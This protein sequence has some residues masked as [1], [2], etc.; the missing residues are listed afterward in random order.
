MISDD[1]RI[2]FIQ[3]ISSAGQEAW[4]EDSA[5][6]DGVKG[7]PPEWVPNHIGLEFLTIRMLLLQTYSHDEL[8]DYVA[9]ARWL[10]DGG[11]IFEVD[12][13]GKKP[14]PGGWNIGVFLVIAQLVESGKVNATFWVPASSLDDATFWV[15]ASS[16]DDATRAFLDPSAPT[17]DFDPRHT[18]IRV[19]LSDLT[20]DED[21]IP[22]EGGDYIGY[23]PIR[24]P[25][26]ILRDICKLAQ[27][28]EAVRLGQEKGLAL[29]TDEYH[30]AITIKGE[31][32]DRGGRGPGPI[33]KWIAR[34]LKKCPTMKNADLW[35][36]FKEKP[37]RGWSVMENRQGKYLE[38]PTVNDKVSYGR[39][40]NVAKEER[41]K[42]KA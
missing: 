32:F 18:M 12:D 22:D 13:L 33:R 37:Q 15:P 42:L 1:P 20:D 3:T 11:G 28:Q 27:I 4:G 25:F 9:E 36:A 39:F 7:E 38:G 24:T 6:F 30:A 41:N 2:R 35:A 31:K 14:M 17:S 8:L 19:A 29:L 26:A 10:L 40:S 34:Q 16:L 23:R 21:V 5:P